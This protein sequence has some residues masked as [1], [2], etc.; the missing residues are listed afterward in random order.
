VVLQI[1][2][3]CPCAANSKWC[4]GSGRDHCGEVSDFKYGCQLP[5][6]PPSPPLDHDPLPNE[7]IHLDLSDIAM[8]RLQTG[9]PNGGI[10]A[11]VIPTKYRR[12][13]CP[14]VGNAYIWLHSGAGPYYFALSV[15]NTSALG[16][17]VLVEAQ[18]PSGTWVSLERDPNYTSARPQERYGDW[19]TPQGTGPFA[20]P[21]SIRMTDPSGQVLVAQN[22]ITAW[23]SAD[24]TQTQTYYIDT[25]VQF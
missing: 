24:A 22:V 9:D 16:S 2:D 23:A 11:G 1:V 13:P 19:V 20:L 12:V 14:V 15:V 18:M 25:G 3:S 5:P 4:C 21:L 8:A 17:L 10:V 7:S 6:A